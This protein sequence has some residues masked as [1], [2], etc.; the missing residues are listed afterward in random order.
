MPKYLAINKVRTQ[1]SFTHELVLSKLYVIQPFLLKR[2]FQ[3]FVEE[4]QGRS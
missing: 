4:G 3:N 2:T 1:A